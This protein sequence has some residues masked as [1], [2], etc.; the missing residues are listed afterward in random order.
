MFKKQRYE[1]YR[2]LYE[3]FN[4]L[5]LRFYQKSWDMINKSKGEKWTDEFM[6]RLEKRK[7][8]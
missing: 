8:K 4:G 5:G 6:F 7:E 2:A 3:F 1:L